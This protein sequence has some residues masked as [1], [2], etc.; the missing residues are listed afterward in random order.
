MV[1]DP[2]FSMNAGTKAASA[3]VEKCFERIDR[4]PPEVNQNGALSELLLRSGHYSD[5][6]NDVQAYKKDLVSW[7]AI[8]SKPKPI[9]AGLSSSDRDILTN[10][11]K[12]MLRSE[13]ER[14][15]VLERKTSLTLMTTENV[16][17]HQNLTV[18]LYCLVPQKCTGILSSVY[19]LEE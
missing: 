19:M 10:W 9:L 13:F 2:E 7:P 16:T 3:H 5:V 11:D 14:E 17:L 18:T 1:P 6:R 8:G 4:P 12:T 15:R